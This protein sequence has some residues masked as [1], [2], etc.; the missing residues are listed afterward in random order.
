MTNTI[1]AATRSGPRKVLIALAIATS[2]L[3][4]LAASASATI[5]P[6]NDA[7]SLQA[8]I[9]AANGNAGHDKIVMAD[10]FYSPT[11]G[12]TI[13]DR[14]TITGDHASEGGFSGPTL[15]GLSVVPL[16]ADTFTVASGVTVDF[17]GFTITVAS[18]FPGAVIRNNGD[19]RMHN[20]LLAGNFGIP[21]FGGSGSTALISN[22][23]IGD[24]ATTSLD[25]LSGGT[26][27]LAN[28]TVFRNGSGVGVSTLNLVNTIVNENAG[29]ECI[30]PPDTQV[31]SIADD[32]TCTGATVADA[33]LTDG[34]GPDAFGGPTPS[35]PPAAGSPAINAGN[36]AQCTTVDQRFNLR[37][38]GGQ[39]DIGAF[40]VNAVEDTTLPSCVVTATRRGG[41]SAP[42]E[43]DVTLRDGESGL[44]ID[45]VYSEEIRIRPSSETTGSF[46]FTPKASV[47]RS[48]VSAPAPSDNG[49]V[50]T[51]R[52][53]G[54]GGAANDPRMR[55]EFTARDWAGNVQECS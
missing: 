54:A 46:L 33:R 31:S 14:L 55:W 24:N 10:G 17:I 19:V 4:A 32:T 2:A 47:F 18:S 6:V 7:A 29:P 28:S 48:P 13:T 3:L 34:G 30:Q 44:G 11:A 27:T 38:S 20:M 45:A 1:T 39:C 51:A 26:V 8:A 5:Y 41:A 35:Y 50:I 43:Q 15:D 37:P 52:K 12:M 36:N 49:L 21:Y 40:E 22:T 9:T 16:E 23:A 42:D 53:S 25:A